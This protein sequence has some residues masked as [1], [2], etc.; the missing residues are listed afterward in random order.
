MHLQDSAAGLMLVGY[1]PQTRTMCII[2]MQENGF[3][4]GPRIPRVTDL[5][6]T[7]LVADH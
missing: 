7:K 6:M 4:S 3:R 5:L 1:D 2:G